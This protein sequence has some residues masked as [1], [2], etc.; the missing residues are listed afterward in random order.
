MRPCPSISADPPPRHASTSTVMT[1]RSSTSSN[2]FFKDQ[3]ARS[4][5][6]EGAE[7]RLRA[8]PSTPGGQLILRVHGLAATNSRL[9]IHSVTKGVESEERRSSRGRQAAGTGEVR[10]VAEESK[11]CTPSGTL[12]PRR[13]GRQVTEE[14]PRL[15]R[16]RITAAGGQHPRRRKTVATWG[17]V[18]AGRRGRRSVDHRGSD[19]SDRDRGRPERLEDGAC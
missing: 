9:G 18:P 17:D 1:Q 2:R 10:R 16:Q 14:R 19:C 3:R 12:W 4:T 5:E 6:E 11:A 8:R 7:P 15:L 13:L